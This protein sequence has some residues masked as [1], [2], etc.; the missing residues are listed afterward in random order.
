MGF[1]VRFVKLA[2]T[3][4][5]LANECKK[6]HLKMRCWQFCW[7]CFQLFLCV[8][9]RFGTLAS[10]PEFRTHLNHIPCSFAGTKIVREKSSITP[11]EREPALARACGWR[12]SFR[13]ANPPARAATAWIIGR[14]VPLPVAPG[15]DDY[16]FVPPAAPSSRTDRL[17]ILV[18][19]PSLA[20][21]LRLHNEPSDDTIRK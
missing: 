14:S 11:K 20:R 21:I 15:G 10:K 12:R 8:E 7:H 1:F 9:G 6:T 17:C 13:A 5:L 4:L 3:Q 19:S 18:I 16:A 2:I